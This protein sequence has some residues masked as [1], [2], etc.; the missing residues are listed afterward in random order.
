[1][2]GAF[3]LLMLG[4]SYGLGIYR[5]L[6]SGRGT[7][8]LFTNVD[9]RISVPARLLLSVVAMCAALVVA[10]SGW[11]GQMRIAF[12]GVPAVLLL[13]FLART[14]APLVVRRSVDPRDRRKQ[15]LPY[16][17]TRLT[18]TRRAFAVDR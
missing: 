3:L 5:V 18:Y 11:T 13:S 1:M 10:W 8:E 7:G 16:I 2:L 17:G 6:W 15:E 14:V 12:S 9:H 4:W